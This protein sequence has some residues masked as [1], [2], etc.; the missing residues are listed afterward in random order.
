HGGPRKGGAVVLGP[1]RGP[2]P[3][4]APA[5]AALFVPRRASLLVQ[6]FPVLGRVPVLANAPRPVQDVLSPQE[7]RTR[8]FGALRELL[9]RITERQPLV[10]VIDDL[11]WADADSLALLGALLEPPEA[12]PFLLI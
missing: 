1:S 4:L 11:Q 2:S 5:D 10:I 8:V 12:P 3:H 9:L 6:V 7:L